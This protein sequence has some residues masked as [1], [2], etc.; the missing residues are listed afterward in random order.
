MTTDVRKRPSIE[1]VSRATRSSTAASISPTNITGGNFG[2]V[3]RLVTQ[4]E[5]IQALDKLTDLT[6]EVV[7]EARESLLTGH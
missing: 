4:I 7:D 2:L 6:P 5:R 1:N 3:D